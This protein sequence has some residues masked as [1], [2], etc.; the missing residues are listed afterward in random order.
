MGEKEKK[1]GRSKG[2][3]DGERETESRAAEKANLTQERLKAD[4]TKGITHL[5]TVHPI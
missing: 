2:G 1:E 5:H 4:K 3:K